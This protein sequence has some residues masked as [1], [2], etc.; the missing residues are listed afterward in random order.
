MEGNMIGRIK[1]VA[2]VLALVVSLFVGY[3]SSKA[4]EQGQY[5]SHYD[6]YVL[7]EGEVVNCL[8]PIIIEPPK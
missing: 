6:S 3:H 7:C 1:I 5:C 4:V 2:F 8:F